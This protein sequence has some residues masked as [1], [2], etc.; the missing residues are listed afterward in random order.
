MKVYPILQCVGPFYVGDGVR[1]TADSDGDRFPDV[2]L[3]TC[4]DLVGSEVLPNYCQE[5]RFSLVAFHEGS[6]CVQHVCVCVGG[7]GGG[8]SEGGGGG[9]MCVWIVT[10]LLSV[11]PRF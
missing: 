7:G 4:G 2:P 10:N 6:Q 1:C 8:G 11:F 9:G 5:V 3:D